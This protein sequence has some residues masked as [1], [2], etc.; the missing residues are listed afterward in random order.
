MISENGELI[1]MFPLA[2]LFG[3]PG[4]HADPTDGLI[5]IVESEGQ[6]TGLLV[7]TLLGHQ[8]IVIKGLGKAM[9]GIPGISG[10]AIMGDGQVSLILDVSG[11]V[12]MSHGEAVEQGNR[13][14]S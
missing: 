1:P 12:R 14:Q 5:V 2:D 9:E 6:R 8:Q 13:R 11:L 4:T 7:D 10:G 3:I